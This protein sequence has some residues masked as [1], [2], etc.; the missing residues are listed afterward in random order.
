MVEAGGVGFRTGDDGALGCVNYGSHFR[1]HLA[2]ELR[3]QIRDRNW[4]L[5]RGPVVRFFWFGVWRLFE[6]PGLERLLSFLKL[7]H[8]HAHPSLMGATLI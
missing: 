3:A 4:L 8:G 7:T 2:L 1:I 5:H 6:D